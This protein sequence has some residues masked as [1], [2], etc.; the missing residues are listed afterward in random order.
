MH[1]C[2]KNT[3]TLHQ[4]SW[5]ALEIR[6]WYEYD[7][8][9]KWDHR[10]KIKI[11]YLSNVMATR[12]VTKTSGPL[13]SLPSLKRESFL[14][15]TVE[16]E[17]FDPHY[18][19][20]PLTLNYAPCSLWWINVFTSNASQ[21]FKKRKSKYF[22]LRKH[23]HHF[24]F[25]LTIVYRPI[26]WRTHSYK[27]IIMKTLF[28]KIPTHDFLSPFIFRYVQLWRGRKTSQVCEIVGYFE[29]K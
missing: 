26:F 19:P 23:H 10:H 17:L 15:S 21:I 22:I 1:R 7:G 20:S 28:H 5:W 4:I 25:P 12:K 29:Y 11:G 9:K 24:I 14:F 16:L 3:T 8:H 6:V 2:K 18:L 27:T 13:I